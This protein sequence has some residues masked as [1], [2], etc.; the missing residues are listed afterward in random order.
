[1]VCLSVEGLEGCHSIFS[2]TRDLE[3]N[4]FSDPEV[5]LKEAGTGLT[6]HERIFLIIFFIVINLSI[7]RYLG[8]GRG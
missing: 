4:E 2:I 1:M 5:D 7:H 3:M 6:L 8:G